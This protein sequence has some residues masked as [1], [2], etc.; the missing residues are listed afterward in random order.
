[1]LAWRELPTAFGQSYH[2]FPA[3][4]LLLLATG[5]FVSGVRDLAATFERAAA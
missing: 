5:V 2:G 1:V 3:W 4:M